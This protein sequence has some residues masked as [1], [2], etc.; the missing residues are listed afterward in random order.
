ME[1]LRRWKLWLSI[2]ITA[3][4]IIIGYEIK[5]SQYF[6]AV[7]PIIIAVFLF[8]LT[9]RFAV[10][11]TDFLFSLESVRRFF[12]NKSNVEGYWVIKTF[13][14]EQ[15]PNKDNPLFKTGILRLTFVGKDL[16]LK[17]VTSRLDDFHTRVLVNSVVAF[18]NDDLS[19]IY[20]LNYFD[21]PVH[22]KDMHH[23]ICFAEFSFPDGK[24]MILQ[25]KIVLEGEGELRMQSANKIS[26]KDVRK[27]IKKFG[28][29]DWIEETLKHDGNINEALSK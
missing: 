27:L 11:L 19:K 20:Y 22:G 4:F 28:N 2:T 12:S 25:G 8:L 23:G 21:Y 3:V 26:R 18:V 24:N 29:K 17:A 16:R 1:R 9:S 14:Q 15:N 13:F 5:L 7:P 10:S 6:E